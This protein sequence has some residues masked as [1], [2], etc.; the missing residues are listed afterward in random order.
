MMMFGFTQQGKSQISSTGKTFY[1]SF[2]E[3]ETRSG[4]YPDTLLIFVTSSVNT[5]LV[6]DNPRLTGSSINY[7]ITANKF[8]V[9]PNCINPEQAQNADAQKA[10]KINAFN[11]S[12]RKVIGFVGSMFPYHGVDVLI[13]SFSKVI[14]AFPNAGVWL[15]SCR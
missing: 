7:N 14:A 5:T 12:S 1:M 6:L 10:H 8:L 3:M 13:N 2:M 11:K 15:R 4:G 9:Q